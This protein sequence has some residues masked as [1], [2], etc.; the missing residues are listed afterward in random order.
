MKPVFNLWLFLSLWIEVLILK[1]RYRNI[2]VYD[3][4]RY[5]IGGAY[6]YGTMTNN[7]FYRYMEFFLTPH[8]G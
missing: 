1:E 8:A 5:I 6:Q 4:D 2:E 3:T 7:D